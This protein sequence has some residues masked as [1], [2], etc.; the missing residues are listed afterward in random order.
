MSAH[1]DTVRLEEYTGV[2]QDK[3]VVVWQSPDAVVPWLP[4]EFMPAAYIT[5]ILITGRNSPISTGLTA[6]PSWTQVWRSPGARE[7]SCLLG[8]L[9]HLPGPVLIVIGPDISLSPGLISN[10]QSITATVIVTRSVTGPGWIHSPSSPDQIFLPIL[11]NNSPASLN[12][13]FNE[14]ASHTLP[15]LDPKVLLPQLAAQGYGLTTTNGNWFWYRP[16]ESGG[17]VTMTPNQI[18]RQLNILSALVEKL[19]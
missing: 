5:R 18:A 4:T 19:T 11:G 2:L 13:I 7:W 12:S 14:F 9:P 15:K 10:L 6:D 17:L 3:M 8:I 1:S 16:A